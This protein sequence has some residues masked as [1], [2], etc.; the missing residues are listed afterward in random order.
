VFSRTS[1]NP[2]GVVSIEGT[3]TEGGNN[4]YTRKMDPLNNWFQNEASAG[5]FYVTSNNDLYFVKVRGVGSSMIEVHQGGSTRGF[6]EEPYHYTTAN[7]I[8]GPMLGT[9]CL[10]KCTQPIQAQYQL[11]YRW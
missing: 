2:D 6:F 3:G 9:I 10:D 5:D 1:G 8:T 11:Y 4:N 7:R